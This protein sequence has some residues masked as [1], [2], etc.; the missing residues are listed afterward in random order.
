MILAHAPHR[1]MFLAGAVQLIL[2]VFLWLTELTARHLGTSVFS[3]TTPPVYLH[4]VMMYFGVFPFFMFGF[5]LTVFP[6]WLRSPADGRAGYLAAWM[7]MSIG[8]LVVYASVLSGANGTA[9]GLFLCALGWGVVWWRLL[10]IYRARGAPAGHYEIILLTAVGLGVLLLLVVTAAVA[11]NQFQLLAMALEGALWLFLLPIAFTVA[12]RMIPFFS[13][14]VLRDY[15]VYQPNSLLATGLAAMLGHAVCSVL[16]VSL[17][18]VFDLVLAAAAGWL[19]FKWAIRR[20]MPVLLLAM[21]HIAF[22]WLGISAL[23]Y[24][25]QGLAVQIDGAFLLGRAPLH[26]MGIGFLASLVIA[27]VSRVSLGHSGR[28]LVADQL[29]WLCFLA[30][31]AVAVLRVLADFPFAGRV[32]AGPLYITAAVLWV[33]AA[34]AWSGR[35]VPVYLRPRVDGRPG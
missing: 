5:L 30:F 12:H 14:L 34:V 33:A 32:W 23:L 31:Q 11:R 3:G 6:R 22:A 26:G 27:F 15:Q 35:Y 1:I 10:R 24:A 21:L 2:T 17:I 8:W 13:A 16:G 18:W 4:A 28:G 20:S 29:T 25:A 7:L 19:S 9:A